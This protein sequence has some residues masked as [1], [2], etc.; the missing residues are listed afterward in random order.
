MPS[1]WAYFK[2]R[3]GHG[4]ECSTSGILILSSPC[5]GTF[6]MEV[7]LKSGIGCAQGEMEGV[8]EIVLGTEK[9][10]DAGVEGHSSRGL[11]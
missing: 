1:S 4:R 5:S 7:Q 2:A 8:G 10:Q 9:R 11:G 3:K 6:S